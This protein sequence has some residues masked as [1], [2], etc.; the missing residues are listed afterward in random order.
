MVNAEG[1]SRV[2]YLA[3]NIQVLAKY[4]YVCVILTTRH[5]GKRK[6]I[7]ANETDTVQSMFFRLFSLLY[8]LHQ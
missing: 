8:F 3:R 6:K 1:E 7:V 4:R 5:G 2:N